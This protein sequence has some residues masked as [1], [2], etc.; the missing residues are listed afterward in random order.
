[1]PLYWDEG[2]I[3][4]VFLSQYTL[5][6]LLKSIVQLD[7][8]NY[9]LIETSD[10]ID[11]IISD[12]EFSFGV[13]ESC[14]MLIKGAQSK[15]SVARVGISEDGGEI[16]V[17][18]EIHYRNPLGNEIDAALVVARMIADLEFEVRNDFKLYG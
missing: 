18:V 16:E 17:D 12:F 11:A 7:L 14:E 6:S 8:Y 15:D 5:T 1:M 4:Q 2:K 9:T 10:N 3:V 13:H